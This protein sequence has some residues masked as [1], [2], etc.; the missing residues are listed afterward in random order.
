MYLFS[1]SVVCFTVF[2]KWRL[3]WKEPFVCPLFEELQ[4]LQHVYSHS[5]HLLEQILM[6]T[7]H[8][9][10]YSRTLYE[11]VCMRFVCQVHQTNRR[12]AK[13]S[14][15]LS[16]VSKIYIYFTPLLFVISTNTKSKSDEQNIS[17]L[18]K[19]RQRR[20]KYSTPWVKVIVHTFLY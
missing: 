2:N 3:C 12:G 16:T 14:A 18:L 9:N 5:V 8:F 15:S 10:S 7:L 1:Y 13:Q 4:H 20:R 6:N 17:A 19:L 11:Q